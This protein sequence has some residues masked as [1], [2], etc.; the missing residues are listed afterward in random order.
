MNR[1]SRSRRTRHAGCR[2][3]G[4]GSARCSRRG[5]ARLRTL[6]RCPRASNES[7]AVHALQPPGT[8]TSAH[9][10]STRGSIGVNRAIRANGFFRCAMVTRATVPGTTGH[11]VTNRVT[12]RQALPTRPPGGGRDLLPL[13]RCRRARGRRGDRRR[14]PHGRPGVQGD[15]GRAAVRD[16]RLLRATRGVPAWWLIR[17]RTGGRRCSRLVPESSSCSMTRSP[18]SSRS[19]TPISCMRACSTTGASPVSARSTTT[20]RSTR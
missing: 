5:L 3:T 17:S 15:R 20:C 19:R 14:R 6:G 1:P 13:C 2:R 8:P 10:A 4:S 16:L 18:S 12:L 9:A 11:W 7:S